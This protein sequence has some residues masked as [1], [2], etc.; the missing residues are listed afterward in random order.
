[1]TSLICGILKKKKDTKK[2]ISKTETGSQISK[3]KLMVAKGERSG[4]GTN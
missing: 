1:M 4:E 2:L 3:T